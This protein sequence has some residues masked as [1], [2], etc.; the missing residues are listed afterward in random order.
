M[1]LGPSDVNTPPSAMRPSRPTL[2]VVSTSNSGPASQ[3]KSSESD[4]PMAQ[5]YGLTCHGL[6]SS[7]AAS[8]GWFRILLSVMECGD[9]SLDFREA[10]RGQE[11]CSDGTIC[12]MGQKLFQHI[13]DRDGWRCRASEM[14]LWGAAS[15]GSWRKTSFHV[16]NQ[17]HP[18]TRC[19]LPLAGKTSEGV[20]NRIETSCSEGHFRGAQMPVLLQHWGGGTA[21]CLRPWWGAGG[22]PGFSC[23]WGRALCPWATLQ[24]QS[25]VCRAGCITGPC[26]SP[27]SKVGA[28]MTPPGVGYKRHV[29]EEKVIRSDKCGFTKGKLR[30]TN[31]ITL[32]G[33]MSGWVDEGTCEEDGDRLF[34]VVPMAGQGARGT[35][36]SA[37]SSS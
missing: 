1:N 17:L 3:A 33:G 18:H 5:T 28:L 12:S 24:Q 8:A 14:G 26:P 11:F 32:Y 19:C 15:K 13:P 10:S 6:P 31:V 22:G 30:V 34:S 37:G 9:I 2:L 7:A 16:G 29:E 27:C 23:V 35:N 4:A 21:P 36:C 20:S 25:G